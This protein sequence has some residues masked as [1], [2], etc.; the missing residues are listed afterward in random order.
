ML[1]GE[2]KLLYGLYFFGT[3]RGFGGVGDRTYV[4]GLGVPCEQFAGCG[5]GDYDVE[6]VE[7]HVAYGDYLVVDFFG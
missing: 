1:A 5:V 4:G 2:E 6:L 3:E 7:R